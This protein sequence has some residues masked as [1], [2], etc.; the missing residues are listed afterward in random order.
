MVLI[1]NVSKQHS[2]SRFPG[3]FA[4]LDKFSLWTDLFDPT[5][6]MLVVSEEDAAKSA[7]RPL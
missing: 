1:V 4:C 6:L 3:T 2:H 7:R 5:R